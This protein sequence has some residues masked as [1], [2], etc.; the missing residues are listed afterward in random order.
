MRARWMCGHPRAFMRSSATSTL[1]MPDH[2]SDISGP[3][4]RG[5]AFSFCYGYIAALLQAAGGFYPGSVQP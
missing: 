3:N 5:I 4:P 2:V 1:L